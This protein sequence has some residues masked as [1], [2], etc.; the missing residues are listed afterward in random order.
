[1]WMDEVKNG[2]RFGNGISYGTRSKTR[3]RDEVRTT[4]MY[5]AYY[6]IKRL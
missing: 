3:V 4:N 5:S 1:M 2:V 6:L